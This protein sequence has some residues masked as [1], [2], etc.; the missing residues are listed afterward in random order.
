[1]MDACVVCDQGEKGESGLVIGPDGNLLTLEGLRGLKVSVA[2]FYSVRFCCK[3]L[4]GI[5]YHSSFLFSC[6]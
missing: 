2:T 4:D 5:R 1:M 3:Y 6:F